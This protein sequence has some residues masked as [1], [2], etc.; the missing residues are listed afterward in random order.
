MMEV[1]RTGLLHALVRGA[2][3][4]EAVVLARLVFLRHG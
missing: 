4:L 2:V 3:L 1:T